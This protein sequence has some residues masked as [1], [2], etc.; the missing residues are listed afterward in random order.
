MSILELYKV[1][2]PD[3]AHISYVQIFLLF[4]LCILEVKEQIFSK[5]QD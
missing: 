1:L 3:L 5:V 2:V 4:I